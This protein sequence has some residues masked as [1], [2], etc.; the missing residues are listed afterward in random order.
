[1]AARL[2]FPPRG[3]QPLYRSSERLRLCEK[4]QAQKVFVAA[5]GG[6]MRSRQHN[7]AMAQRHLREFAGIAV[8]KFHPE[9]ES[10]TRHAKGPLRKMFLKKHG[11]QIAAGF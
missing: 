8:R 7:Q 10:A 11:Q 1:M 9:E 6:G 2:I 4:R 5:D 3:R